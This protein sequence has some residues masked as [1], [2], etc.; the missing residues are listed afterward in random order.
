MENVTAKFKFTLLAA[1]GTQ[2]HNT[3]L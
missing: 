2:L 3:D 1:D